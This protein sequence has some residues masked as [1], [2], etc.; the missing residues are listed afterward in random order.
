MNIATIPAR[1]PSRQP[2][3]REQLVCRWALALSNSIDLSTRKN[4]GSACNSYLT[5]VCLH[6]LLVEPTPETLS[7]FVIFMSSHINQLQPYFPDVLEARHS[8]LVK[9][10]MEGCLK[11]H[12]EPTERKEALTLSDVNHIITR[13]ADTH[14]HDDL[15]FVAMFLTVFFTLHRLGELAFPDNS[16]IRNWCKVIHRSSVTFH[17]NRY[18]YTLPSHKADRQFQGSKVVVWGDAVPF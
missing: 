5:F 7:F 4:Y 16:T 8:T 10:T 9:R 2:W 15:L 17:P 12:A 3:S 11:L 6:D 1:Q 13:F 14:D 18:G